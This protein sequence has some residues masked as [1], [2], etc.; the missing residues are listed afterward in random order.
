MNDWD[1]LIHVE[2]TN[3]KVMSDT[4]RTDAFV[5][6]MADEG[7]DMEEREKQL[8]DFAK[9]LEHELAAMTAERDT[10][11]EML[12][13]GLANEIMILQ[14]RDDALKECAELRQLLRIY[15]SEQIEDEV[16]KALKLS[17]RS[18]P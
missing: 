6:G 14:E 11:N 5:R 12:A 10:S 9:T 17:P 2:P 4:P 16:R 7:L 13:T 1:S 15:C 18:Q 3:T 8:K